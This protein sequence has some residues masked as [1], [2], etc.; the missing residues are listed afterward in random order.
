M[1]KNYLKIAI[2]TL[3]KNRLFTAINFLGLSLGLASAGVL[4]LFIQRGVTFDTFHENNDQ[5]YYVQ[6]ETKGE[7][8]NAT[9]HPIMQQLIRTFPEIETGTH[10][11]GWNDVWLTY[12]GKNIQGNTKYVDSSF[13]DIFSFKLKY[14]DPKTAFKSRQSIIINQKIAQALF[15][16]RNPVGETVSVSDTLNFTVAGVLDRVP[17]NSSM[18]FEVL[19]PISL[20]EANAGF[21][22]GADWYNTFS[23]VYLKIKKGTDIAKLEA[24]FPTFAKTHF[25]PAGGERQVRIEKL[26][27]FIHYDNPG[28]KW[29][30]YGAI[31]IVIF[32][33][34]II[35]INLINLNTAIAFTRAK[36]IAVRKV[37]GSNLKQILV[38]FWTESAI[39]LIASLMFAVVLAASYLVPQFNEFRQGRMQLTLS[40]EQDYMT[41][42]ALG[43][44]ITF[45]A[46]IAG[47]YPAVYLNRLDLRDT[48]KGKLS[49][50][51]HSRNWSRGTMIV[52]QFVI[53]FA[54]VI[55]AI[56]VRK[57]VS[58]MREAKTGFDKE[59][60]V[61][62]QSDLEYRDTKSA[63]IQFKSI[64]N[65]LRQ[66]SR[67]QSIA[68]SSVVPSK[69]WSNYNTYMADGA[70]GAEVR[71]KH[72]G[73]GPGYSKTYGIKMLEGRDFSEEIDKDGKNL[74]VV[75]NESAMKALG[76]KTAVGKRI[77]QKSNPE[78]YTIIGVMQDF[79]YQE[80]KEK[81]EPLLHW[82]NGPAGLSSYLSIRLND[83]GQAKSV[84]AGLEGKMKK[85]PARKPFGAFYMT[86]ELSRQ[87][88]HLDGIWKMVNFV[89]TLAIVIALA[90]IFGLITLAANQR[91]KEVG[92]RKVLGA[93]VQEV[94]FLLAKDFVILVLIGIVIGAPVAYS[95]ESRYLETF[96]YHTRLGWLTYLLVGCT[97]LLLTSLTVGFQSIKTA[98]MNPVD[99][100]KSE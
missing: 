54:L 40:W 52:A 44:I 88:N 11:Q 15:G 99:S 37:T 81:I 56:V 59:N 85:I 90:G 9:V 32:I 14:G 33:L 94:T 27:N 18:Q 53:A 16:D 95:F 20:L 25:D 30:I 78:V 21:R 67:V 17:E 7:R 68:T 46:L 49:N 63:A 22:S 64:L 13:F 71:I 26:E 43:G 76:W 47:T 51:T 100:L 38:Q 69:Y 2:R 45:I 4:I 84:L 6:T 5:I 31:G 65:E 12:R 3:W 72:S 34:L 23:S 96:T 57:Q 80:L 62:V 91:M 97:A 19:V 35:S 86:D 82:Y 50:K 79:H 55:G 41:V 29:M 75:I 87:Y 58:F 1:L 10:F 24:Q 93:S 66:D 73:T 48:I 74:P 8:Y 83:M 39:V 60:V 77:R 42:I 92:I 36:E 70:V 89:A 98:L 61:V 28:F